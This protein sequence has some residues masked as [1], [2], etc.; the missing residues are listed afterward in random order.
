[1]VLKLHGMHMSTC[2][3]KVAATLV[4][5]HVPFEF[6]SVDIFKGEHKQPA[7]LKNQ[8]FGVV[9]FIVRYTFHLSFSF[10]LVD[11]LG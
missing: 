7:H 10:F 6:V 11:S 5:K 8:P 3:R 1:M 9:P 4:E 2:T